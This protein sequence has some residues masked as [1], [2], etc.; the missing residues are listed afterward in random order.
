MVRPGAGV[1]DGSMSPSA[2]R[3]AQVVRA[4]VAGDVLA[5]QSLVHPDVV[6]HSAAPGQPDG[7]AGLRERA[8]TMCT[9]VHDSAAPV[10]VLCVDGDAAMCRVQLVGVPRR[11]SLAPQPGSLVVV[12]VLRFE[13]DLLRELWTSTAVRLPVWA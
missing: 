7:W 4:L 5:L 10:D 8:M 12:F 11:G 13:D 9:A 6:D 3:S 1:E 2:V